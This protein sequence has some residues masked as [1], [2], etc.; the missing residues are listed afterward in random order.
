MYAQEA[1]NDTALVEDLAK[2][3]KDVACLHGFLVR[4]KEPKNSE[5]VTYLPFTLFP[6]PIQRAAYY[7][8]IEVQNHYNTLMDR[9]SQDTDFLEEALSST[10][11]V[12]KFTARLFRIHK[13]MLKEGKSPTVVLGLN[14]SDYMVDQAQ[15]GRPSLKQIEFNTFAAGAGGLAAAIVNV[16]KNILTVAGRHEESQRVLENNPPAGQAKAMAKAWELY[17][18]KR[19]VLLMIINKEERN[20][21]DQRW[22][23]MALLKLN[24][25]MILRCFKDV[26]TNGFLDEDNRL[27]VDGKEIAVVYFRDGYTPQQYSSEE[28]WEAR[29]MIERSLAVKCPD[30]AT[31]LAGTKK[32][33]QVL[34]QP[35]VLERFFPGQ[36]YVVEQ[37][38]STF[39]GLYSLD[40]GPEG[41]R[42]F[43][44]ALA[45]PERF[46]LKPQR[47]GGGNNIYG[48]NICE[49]LKKITAEE[50]S[51][52]ILM[53]KVRPIPSPN[54]LL[55]HDTP[56]T[57]T[58]CLSELGVYGAYVRHGKDMVMNE[59]VGHLL[60]TKVATFSDGGIL[61]GA[62]GLDNPLLF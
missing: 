56:L 32:I 14:R 12:D 16:H 29:L 51:C 50:R 27:F 6:T 25:P 28:D 49:V 4:P 17:G 34:A 11:K 43:E 60:R 20:V 53:E 3:A 47:E 54:I 13:Q 45:D 48:S 41:D 38:R 44:M 57:I 55:R 24:L 37:I 22:L 7:Q 40:V 5:L 33:Q 26:S 10:M 46:V 8:A 62:A 23:Q 2:F 31:H 35:G 39:T 42:T 15:D 61:K 21:F 9:V 1:M 30:I 36:P 18:S 19:A 52:C 58:D 59:T